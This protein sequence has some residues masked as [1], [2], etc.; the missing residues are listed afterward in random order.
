MKV[1][2]LA[3]PKWQQLKI[4]LNGSWAAPSPIEDKSR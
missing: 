1:I 2:A 4:Q 3:R